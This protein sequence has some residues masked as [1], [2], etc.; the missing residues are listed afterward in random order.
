MI[1]R[2]KRGEIEKRTCGRRRERKQ[3]EIIGE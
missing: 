1:W 2:R 3:K